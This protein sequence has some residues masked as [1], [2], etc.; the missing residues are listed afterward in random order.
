ML[1]DKIS[2]CPG[3]CTSSSSESSSLSE[4]GSAPDADGPPT[5]G[6]DILAVSTAVCKGMA[7]VPVVTD[8]IV[9]YEI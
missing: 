8:V 4:E 7:A 9:G 2:S 6:V 5:D 1:P 3:A